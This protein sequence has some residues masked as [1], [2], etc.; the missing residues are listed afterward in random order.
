MAGYG[1]D[2]GFT[3]YAAAAGY[4]VPTGTIAAAR[5]RGSVFI[6][7]LY[8]IRFTG[9]PTGGAAQEREWPRTGA[10]DRYGNA[11]PSDEVP[12]RV[13]NASYEAALLE[14]QNPG[15]LSVVTSGTSL[16]KSERVEGVITVEYAVSENTNLMDKAAPFSTLID[17][18]LAPLLQPA[19][20][21]AALVV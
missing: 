15:S 20:L 4:T 9:T 21:P 11:L 12:V 18:I 16:V 5:Q 8:G 10:T 1:D 19:F 2:D 17:G 7:G 6:D 14:L 3:A 13:V